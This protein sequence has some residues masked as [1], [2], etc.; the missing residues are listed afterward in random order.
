MSLDLRIALQWLDFIA[1]AGIRTPLERG[2][3]DVSLAKHMA[4]LSMPTAPVEDRL[5]HLAGD[6]R[7]D[8]LILTHLRRGLQVDIPWALAY[9]HSARPRRL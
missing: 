1:R 9:C 8:R 7:D 2:H 4:D 6:S 5:W 3:V